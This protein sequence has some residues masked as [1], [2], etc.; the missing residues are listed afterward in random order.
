MIDAPSAE[1]GSLEIMENCTA[2]FLGKRTGSVE[3]A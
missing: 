3:N 1:S 2:V